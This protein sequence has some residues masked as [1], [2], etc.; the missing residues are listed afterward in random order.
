M[1]A[2]GID[3]RVLRKLISSL[4][5]EERAQNAIILT[6]FLS[7]LER[8]SDLSS[9][10]RAKRVRENF[11]QLVGISYREFCNLTESI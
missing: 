2:D 9:A 6:G 8:R 4:G 11:E 1:Y 10:A 3:A 7:K 5:S